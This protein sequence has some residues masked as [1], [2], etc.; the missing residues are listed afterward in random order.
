MTDEQIIELL[1]KRINITD[2]GCWEFLPYR[3]RTGQFKKNRYTGEKTAEK[4]YPTLTVNGKD[5][6]IHRLSW[7]IHN[8]GTEK[9][10]KGMVICHKCDNPP[11]C[12]PDH[13]YQGTFKDNRADRIK[14][15]NKENN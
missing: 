5:W 9:L 7:A 4:K 6:H 12:N 8:G 3:K 14:F 10:I 2:N 13:L 1:K 11:C 15:Q